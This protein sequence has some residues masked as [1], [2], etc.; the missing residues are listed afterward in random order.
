[1]CH[2]KTLEMGHVIKC[3]THFVLCLIV[4]LVFAIT[5]PMDLTVVSFMSAVNNFGSGWLNLKNI[6]TIC[7]LL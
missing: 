5:L 2:D 6:P 3:C 1:M 4:T 7:Q